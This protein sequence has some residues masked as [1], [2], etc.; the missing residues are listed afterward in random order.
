[1]AAH[2]RNL[3]PKV[4]ARLLRWGVGLC[5]LV[6]LG[7]A[8]WLALQSPGGLRRYVLATLSPQDAQRALATLSAAQWER[9]HGGLATL[10]AVYGVAL[11]LVALYW[12]A[13]VRL[14][15]QYTTD[16]ARLFRL[17]AT[18]PG[19][20]I[21]GLGFC[22]A[23]AGS[24]VGWQLLQLPVI[25]DEANVYVSYV[26][27]GPLVALGYAP[28]ASNHLLHTGLSAVV[29]LLPGQWGV[30]AMRLPA[31]VAGGLAVW[32]FAR[33]QWIRHSPAMGLASVLLL[34]ANY[35]VLL[36]TTHGRGYSMVL[37]ATLL[38]WHAVER[39]QQHGPD[40]AAARLW[41]F[42]LVLGA[43]S[44][45]TFAYPL[46]L[47]VGALAIG[48]RPVRRAG[49]WRQFLQS[50]LWGAAIGLL[51]WLP[52]LLSSGTELLGS[53]ARAEGF[54]SFWGAT[55]AEWQTYLLRT[56]THVN[57]TGCTGPTFY[58]LYF[59]GLWGLWQ[60]GRPRRA[61]AYG[62]FLLGSILVLPALQNV[63]PPEKTFLFL[64]PFYLGLLQ[65]NLQRVR[66]LTGLWRGALLVL[67]LGVFV[68]GALQF[69]QRHWATF[70]L[71]RE[72][73]VFFRCP[74]AAVLRPATQLPVTDGGVYTLWRYYQRTHQLPPGFPE[75]ILETP[76]TQAHHYPPQKNTPNRN[77]RG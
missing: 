67:A 49:V 72:A 37:L 64:T 9:L 74:H 66:R 15:R 16:T 2:L 18:R 28:I 50:S 8:G 22:L 51:I 46:V 19:W 35:Q 63:L 71:A 39:W 13:V 68:A 52:A 69:R 4:T 41:G 70:Q 75:F 44:V 55:S 76:A 33:R 40:S 27:R 60:Q 21:V 59:L 5:G 54:P 38:G 36:Y 1:M 73:A 31:A 23:L 12:W 58:I 29:E 32:L 65:E 26:A 61:L 10:M 47:L 17:Q 45:L 34:F 62:W 57:L 20:V 24:F 48:L 25:I 77:D 7:L 53:L 56:A 42:A 6:G 43:T 30:L 3:L 11:L 14:V